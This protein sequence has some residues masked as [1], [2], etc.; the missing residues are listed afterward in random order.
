MLSTCRFEFRYR[1]A[2]GARLHDPPPSTRKRVQCGW[3]GIAKARAIGGERDHRTA[4]GRAASSLPPAGRKMG[5]R[6]RSAPPGVHSLQ[7]E[8][9]GPLSSGA[10][11]LGTG[12]GP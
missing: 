2:H 7:R 12:L 9:Q 1:N 4:G 6:R 8:G 5:T 11:S 3:L 10:L